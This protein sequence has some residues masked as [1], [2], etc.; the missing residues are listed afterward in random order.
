MTLASLIHLVTQRGLAESEEHGTVGWETSTGVY[1]IDVPGK[2]GFRYIL[3]LC[4]AIFL[5]LKKTY[6]TDAKIFGY[7][8]L[9]VFKAPKLS[10]HLLQLHS[11]RRLY[12]LI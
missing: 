10:V 6:K 1:T 5:V 2:S 3:F 8:Y 11:F 9:L 4:V 7:T 12:G